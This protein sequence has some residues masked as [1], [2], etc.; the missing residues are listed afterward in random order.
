MINEENEAIKKIT[1]FIIAEIR[2]GT[3]K[4][5]IIEKL[6][7]MGADSESA[8]AVVE[9]V[10][11]YAIDRAK[12]ERFTNEFL[13][14]ALIGGIGAAIISGI[15]WGLLVILTGYEFGFAAW[16]V[17]FLCGYGVLLLTKGKKGAPL[18][19]IAIV[20]S[21]LGIFIGKYI[22]FFHFL[23]EAISTEYGAE[24]AGEISLLSKNLITLFI[25]HL[26]AVISGFDLLWIGIAITTAWKLLKGIGINLPESEL[27]L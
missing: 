26:D 22:T 6:V 15:L 24:I 14:T 8:N 1:N 7:Q 12:R 16:G 27:S 21:L 23:K 25:N 3:E 4:E 2:A 19:G 17:G 11:K 9:E 13:P 10:Y 5:K 18:Q 20:S